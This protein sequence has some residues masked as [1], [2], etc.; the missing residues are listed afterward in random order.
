M[1]SAFNHK[2]AIMCICFNFGLN[3][4]SGFVN[5]EVSM[6]RTGCRVVKACCMPAYVKKPS[7]AMKD[8]RMR[9]NVAVRFRYSIAWIFISYVMLSLTSD[10][11][12]AVAAN[13]MRL[14][15]KQL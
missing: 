1:W 11:S 10:D 14:R 12:T 13:V 8:R 9:V 7:V 15:A 6:R 5:L 4:Q 2:K 3:I